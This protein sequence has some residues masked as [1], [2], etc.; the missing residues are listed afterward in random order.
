MAVAAYGVRVLTKRIIARLDIKSPNLVKGQQMEG[1]RVVGKPSEYAERY[2]ND[3]ADEIFY[4]DIVA[5]LYGRNGLA[6]LVADT[7]RR[8]FIPLTVGG[9]LRSVADMR[10]MFVAGADKI[11]INTA[12]IARPEL[13]TEAAHAYGS[14]AVVVAI[15]MM[16]RNGR[17]ECFTDNGRN[18]TG[19]DAF[20]WAKQAVELGAGE[21]LIT[22]I[23]HE[24]LRRG[25]DTDSIKRISESV[26]VPVV[27]HGGAGS[28]EHILDAYK[29]G[30]DGVALA[31]V[32]HWNHLTIPVIKGAL[33]EAGMVI[34]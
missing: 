27:A 20:E 25:M 2:Y 18:P 11:V 19:K 7:A 8:V 22:S 1:L 6:D 28:A 5:S 33:D 32:L 9:G 14:Q 4:I 16:P 21:L 3:K 24:G 30:A 26:R 23:A 13:I 12:A 10:T 34:R 29:A 31:S 17:M 15:E